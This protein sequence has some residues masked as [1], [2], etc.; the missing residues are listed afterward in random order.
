MLIKVMQLSKFTDYGLRVL[1]QLAANDPDRVSV[2]KIATSFKI[3]DNHV[4][5]VAS[6]LVKG[7]FVTS[8]RG[9]AGGLTLAKPADQINIGAVVRYM[10]GDVPVAE[11]FSK[12]GNECAAFAQ[13]GLRGPL[14]DAQQ[15]FFNVLDKYTV[16]QVIKDRHLM[17]GLLA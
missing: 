17:A 4:A 10:S 9:R 6:A 7:G 13:C 16:E 14:F 3:S 15:A 1:L 8:G 2:G 5:K 12:D 11:C